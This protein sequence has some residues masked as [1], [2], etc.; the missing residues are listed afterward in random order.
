MLIKY[1]NIRGF[2]GIL[3]EISLHPARLN[4]LVGRNNV[5]K[6]SILDAVSLVGSSLCDYEDV[7][8]KNIIEGILLGKKKIKPE[9]LINVQERSANI[10]M[11]LSNGYVTSLSIRLYNNLSE[12]IHDDEFAY[13][14]LIRWIEGK[15]RKLVDKLVALLAKAVSYTHLTLPTKA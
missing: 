12:L 9:H 3:N 1:I 14:C 5:G 6:S 10:T 15:I 11:L 4:I 7:L 8:G 2:R 13:E